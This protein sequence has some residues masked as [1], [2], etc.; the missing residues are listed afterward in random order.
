MSIKTITDDSAARERIKND[1]LTNLFVEAGAGSGKTTQLVERL[2]SLV[3]D[4]DVDISRIC[5]LTFTKAAAGEFY[6][7]FQARLAECALTDPDRETRA[8]CADALANIDSCFMGTL[9]SFSEL[10]LR[11]NPIAAGIPSDFTVCAEEELDS[12]Y[13]SA[14]ADIVKGEYGADVREKYERLRVK[15][16][17]PGYFFVQAAAALEK[18]RDTEI[19][20]PSGYEPD[21]DIF[22]AEEKKTLINLLCVL[23]SHPEIVHP[24]KKGENE[25]KLL[26]LQK[27]LPDLIGK[28]WHGRFDEIDGLLKLMEGYTFIYKGEPGDLDISALKYVP[29]DFAPEPIGYALVS[30]GKELE[31]AGQIIRRMDSPKNGFKL[32]FDKFLKKRKEEYICGAALDLVVPMLGIMAERRAAQGNLSFSDAKLCLRDMLRRDAETGGRLIRHIRKHHG[33]FLADEFQDTAPIQTEILLYLSTDTPDPDPMKCVPEARSLFIVGDPKQ[34]IYR[35][36]RADISTFMSAR[37]L[38]AHTPGCDVLELT[39]NHRSTSLL[40]ERFNSIFTELLPKDTK[41]QSA[42]SEIPLTPNAADSGYTGAFRYKTDKDID[43]EAVAEIILNLVNDPAKKVYHRD[44]ET[45]EMTPGRIEYKD[46]MI[47][48]PKKSGIEKYAASL[49]KRGIPYVSEGETLMS[50][51]PSL[52]MLGTVLSALA[53]PDEGIRLYKVL[54]SSLFELTDAEFLEQ[55]PLFSLDQELFPEKGLTDLGRA[56]NK[57]IELRKASTKILPSALCDKIIAELELLS[58]VQ[59]KE[60]EYLF[61]ALDILRQAEAEGK[62]SSVQEAEKLIS[63]MLGNKVKKERSLRFTPDENCVK[64][65]NLH[66]VKG[67]EKNVVILAAPDKGAFPASDAFVN[68]A[69]GKRSYIFSCSY[70]IPTEKGDIYVTLFSTDQFETEREEENKALDAER[71]RLLYVAATRARS[72]LLTAEAPDGARNYWKDITDRIEDEYTFADLPIPAPAPAPDTIDAASVYRATVSPFGD[73]LKENGYTVVLPS[74]LELNKTETKSKKNEGSAFDPAATEP[75]PSPSGRKRD[76]QLL[77]TLVHRL[78]ER[79]VTSPA[80]RDREE[81]VSLVLREHGAEEYYRS[82]LEGVFDRITSG[83]YEQENGMCRDILAELAAAEEI[84]CETPFC[85]KSIGPDGSVV[86]NNG[87]IDLIYRKD[88]RLF[89]IDY[90]TN[91]EK[92]GLDF[93]YAN[94]LAAYRAAIKELTGEDAQ[95]YI[96][97]IDV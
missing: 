51:C 30:S 61:F 17:N 16:R 96:Y 5:A 76:P 1:T 90:K 2:V 18:F 46:I 79:L 3:K 11:E 53:Y 89:I 91:Y 12:F 7:R 88:G 39:E 50:Q 29:K 23:A 94:Q 47:I 80:F 25:K 74:A 33:I 42:F 87:V 45:G 21:Q 78:M 75:A 34:S 28:P 83:G 92:Q 65:A 86:I 69:A 84:S 68:D 48:T 57:L 9:D 32:S 27:A 72:V 81:L 63:D 37:E 10:V 41:Y 36:L 20:I 55:R 40:K 24:D 60:L 66:K 35:F 82:L 26:A 93:H 13:Q 59:A 64:I 43:P 31:D 44:P 22:F 15:E 14:A 4:K 58:H 71:L 8:R 19:Q 52:K 70:T 6:G 73:S 85:Y 62:V 49:A 38:F 56:F 54:T 77:G 95:T 97:H 67:L